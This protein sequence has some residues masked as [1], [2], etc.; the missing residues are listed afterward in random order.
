MGVTAAVN[1]APVRVTL[2]LVRGTL[3]LLH[4]TLPVPL[5]VIYG[6]TLRLITGPHWID[7]MA[8]MLLEALPAVTLAPIEAFIPQVAGAS[9]SSPRSKAVQSPGQQ[10]KVTKFEPPPLPLRLVSTAPVEDDDVTARDAMRI[11]P[12]DTFKETVAIITVL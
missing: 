11:K 1:T 10:L 8:L 3:T 9:Y 2:A 5:T 7:S 6:E 4:V 12:A